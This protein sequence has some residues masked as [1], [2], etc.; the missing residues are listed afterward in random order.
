MSTISRDDYTGHPLVANDLGLF[1]QS[2]VIMETWEKPHIEAYM[3]RILE[4]HRPESVLEVGFGFGYTAQV[5]Y[6][7][8]VP[9]VTIVEAHPQIVVNALR[10]SAGKPGVEL[11]EGFVEDV[12]L[13][14]ALSARIS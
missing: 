1:W 3:R 4:E 6:D 5:I 7:F 8:G 12:A 13:P 11:I 2:V 14:P 10:W 9:F